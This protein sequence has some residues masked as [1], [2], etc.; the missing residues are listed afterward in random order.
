MPLA[1]DA[2]TLHGSCH[3]GRLRIEFS[4][5]QDPADFTRARAIAR[6]VKS[7]GR[8]TFQILPGDSQ[9]LYV[10]APCVNIGRGQTPP[11]SWFVANAACLLR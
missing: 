6:S 7:T 2:V 11:S 9:C 3:C 4:T 1:K 5:G 8:H 10:K